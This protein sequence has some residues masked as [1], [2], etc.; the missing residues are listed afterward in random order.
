MRDAVFQ[1][2][3]WDRLHALVSVNDY[4]KP[5]G[6]RP[7]QFE[8]GDIKR[9]AGHRQP[10]AGLG[11]NRL[12]H[13]GEEVDHVAVLDHHTFGF[14]RRSR[15]VNGIGEIL[16]VGS[17]R[18]RGGGVRGNGFRIAIDGNDVLRGVGQTR[19]RALGGEDDRS[20]RVLDHQLDTRHW[21]AG[22][23][24]NV[25]PARL[26]DRDQP[27]HHFQGTFDGDPDQ[28][29]CLHAERAEM[30]RQLIG[31]PI[32]FAIGQAAPCG[33]YRDCVRRARNL[34]LKQLRHCAL[35]QGAGLGFFA[36]NHFCEQ[37]GCSPGKGIQCQCRERSRWP[38]PAY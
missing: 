24:R 5:A 25:G 37:G 27:D 18:D 13:A 8:H 34:A 2:L 16:P 30:P 1:D 36:F 22:I 26:E 38:L 9:Y 21:I 17:G 10:N 35:A 28:S 19:F 12:I 14:P 23:N 33:N 15:S 4:L 7:E 32:E 29:L 11:P 20:L 6:Q 3:I 31:A